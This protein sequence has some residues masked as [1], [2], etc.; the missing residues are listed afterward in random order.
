MKFLLCFGTRP[1]AIKMAPIYVELKKRNIPCQ[2][3]VTA[4]HRSMLDQVLEY[5][6]IVPDY[7]LGL[8][9]VD[10]S[11]NKLSSKILSEF[12]EILKI[13]LPDIVLVHG[14][15]TT[16]ALAALASFHRQIKV[17][18]I[19]AGL[20]TF[21][22]D[23]P[24]PEE[25]NR[26]L[27]ARIADFHFAPSVIAQ[28]NLLKENVCKDLIL[29][30]GNT[31]VD[32]IQ[33]A[34]RKNQNIYPEQ[35]GL[36]KE[37]FRANLVLV[38]LHRREN[39]G[40]GLEEICEAIKEIAKED[41]Q[42]I[43]P[44]H[45]NPNVRRIVYEILGEIKNLHLV[46]PVPYIMML[47]LI[48]NSKLIISDSGGIQEEA[49]VLKKPV[50]VTRKYTERVEGVEAGYCFLT[51]SNKNEIILKAKEILKKPFIYNELKN[52]YGN[53]NSASKIIDF[54]ISKI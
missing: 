5:F 47:H 30:S 33:M 23:S 14:D 16:S 34:F 22:K 26:Q 36:E 18:H 9:E 31:I 12:D 28:E 42:I 52:P 49:I 4:Q 51:G 45:L 39:L 32:A 15:T 46:E 3:C 35:I 41:V 53:G 17:G 25:L 21:K 2:V 1:E 8:M 10:Q 48:K 19:E 11:L 27:T 54:L 29:I 6:K 43:F 38:T 50:I 20:R 40:K 37:V 13:V 7:D 24:F 44:V